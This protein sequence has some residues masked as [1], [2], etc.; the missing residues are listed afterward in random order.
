MVIPA[1]IPS[2]REQAD[3]GVLRRER[4]PRWVGVVLPVAILG[5]FGLVALY[6]VNRSWLPFVLFL[7][8]SAALGLLTGFAARRSLPH[9]SNSLRWA[10]AM[11][12]LTVGLLAAGIVSGGEVGLGPLLPLVPRVRWGEMVQL[13]SAGLAAWLAVRAFAR[14]QESSQHAPA[15]EPGQANWGFIYHPTIHDTQPIRARRGARP[16][17]ALRASPFAQTTPPPPPAGPATPGRRGRDGRNGCTV[18]PPFR[19]SAPSS[20]KVRPLGRAPDP[21][22]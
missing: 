2:A 9:R 13:T 21:R 16:S 7:A 5:G 22:R 10:V 19:E 15:T 4:I 20:P 3:E 12:A 18:P 11:G 1:T 17:A 8:G 6:G 14:P